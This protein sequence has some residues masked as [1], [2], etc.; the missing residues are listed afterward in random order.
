MLRIVQK[1]GENFGRKFYV[2]AR[3]AVRSMRRSWITPMHCRAMRATPRRDAIS[4]SGSPSRGQE[5]SER[6]TNKLLTFCTMLRRLL[7]IAVRQAPGR[8]WAQS[9]SRHSSIVCAGVASALSS[10]SAHGSRVEALAEYEAK[11]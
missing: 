6:T 10:V 9:T 3:P 7:Q 5:T 2:C 11:V 8:A 1:E 4:S